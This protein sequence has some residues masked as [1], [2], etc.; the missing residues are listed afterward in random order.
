MCTCCACFQAGDNIWVILAMTPGIMSA[1]YSIEYRAHFTHWH[2]TV[3]G[4]IGATE[5]LIFVQIGMLVAFF[6]AGSNNVYHEPLEV[7]GFSFTGG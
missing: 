6:A 5:Q 2:M 3:V 1:H 7:A 4:L